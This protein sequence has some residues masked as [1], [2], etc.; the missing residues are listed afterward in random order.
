[1]PT[2]FLPGH[3]INCGSPNVTTHA[4]LFCTQLCRQIAE[5]VR[6]VRACSHDGRVEQ[7]D[8]CEAIQM[9]VAHVLGGGYPEREREV[10]PAVRS[11]VFE[12]AGGRC[13]NCGR[14]L[15]FAGTSGDLDAQPQIQHVAGSS[16]EPSNLKSFCRRCNMADAQSKF[17]PVEPDSSAAALL[18]ELVRRWSSPEPLLVCDDDR[19]WRYTWRGFAR[20]ARDV[21]TARENA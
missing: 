13:E 15:D 21:I 8:V 14:V 19:Q 9:R 17:V 12:R 1:M 6:Y 2:D 20:A 3:C 18:E 10:S 16:S 7:P 5:V 11:A 4:P